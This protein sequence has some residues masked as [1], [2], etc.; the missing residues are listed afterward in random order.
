MAKRLDIY[1]YE[2]SVLVQYGVDEVFSNCIRAALISKRRGKILG[3]GNLKSVVR[4]HL[5]VPHLPPRPPPPKVA[6][7]E[8]RGREIT[9]LD[10][11]MVG[12]REFTDIVFVVQGQEIE[13]HSVFLIAASSAFQAFLEEMFGVEAKSTSAL[14]LESSLSCSQVTLTRDDSL[15]QKNDFNRRDLEIAD[16]SRRIDE[17][18]EHD[19]GICDDDSRGCDSCALSQAFE[20][21]S[22][23]EYA[24]ALHSCRQRSVS[25]HQY[26]AP[27]LK[28]MTETSWISTG[29][30]QDC[31]AVGSEANSARDSGF[32]VETPTVSS[33]C[34]SS[35]LSH[36]SIEHGK[37]HGRVLVAVDESVTPTQFRTVLRYLYTGDLPEDLANDAFVAL[38]HVARLLNLED[39]DRMITNILNDDAILNLEI[40]KK[41]ELEKSEQLLTLFLGQKYFSGSGQILELF[42]IIFFSSSIHHQN[43]DLK[44]ESTST[45]HGYSNGGPQAKSSPRGAVKWPTKIM[46]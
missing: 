30:L 18:S 5:Q 29:R 17:T 6:E 35:I 24:S 11:A 37:N 19:T 21:L 46:K 14:N 42:V 22:C 45:G 33:S 38:K 9:K 32:D 43:L 44:Y 20:S 2:T 23:D 31:V 8:S 36:H 41:F 27:N 26:Q 4:P 10:A 7:Y 40:K 12:S 34:L 39:L 28:S 1:Y 16:S 13:A 25:A 15:S 3:L